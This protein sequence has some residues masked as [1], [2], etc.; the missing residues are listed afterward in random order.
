MKPI[1]KYPGGKSKEIKFFKDFIPKDFDK[2]IEPFFGGGSLFFHL[3]KDKNIVSDIN[4]NLIRFYKEV[5]KYPERFIKE[6]DF[7]AN[8]YLKNQEKYEKE[9]LLNPDKFINNDNEELYYKL[10]NVFNNKESNPYLFATVYYFINKTAYSGMVRYNSKGEFN[11]PFGRYAKLN[12]SFTPE[13]INLLNNSSIFNCSYEETFSKATKKD[14]IFLDPPYDSIF[15]E[16]G[17]KSKTGDF[18][19]EEQGKLAQDFKNLSTKSLMIINESPLTKELYKDFIKDKYPK[20]YS[21]NIKNRIASE[22]NH[23]IITNYNP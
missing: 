5:Q 23:L 8:L 21:V 7:L 16:Y 10:R 15:T 13:H 17:N 14:F 6:T 11:V 22:A 2:Y 4:S 20:R 1:L 19:E 18:K 3:G 12:K 9:K